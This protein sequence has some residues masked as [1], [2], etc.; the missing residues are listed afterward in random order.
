[1][2]GMLPMIDVK[3]HVVVLIEVDWEESVCRRVI[4][5]Y[6]NKRSIKRE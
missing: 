5:L 6:G 3:R 2:G 1:M 4:L